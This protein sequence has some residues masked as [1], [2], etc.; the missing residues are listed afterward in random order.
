MQRSAPARRKPWRI[1]LPVMGG[2][3]IIAIGLG[4]W[5]A[6]TGGMPETEATLAPKT[7][8]LT[9]PTSA[10][11]S[12]TASAPE[13][14]SPVSQEVPAAEQNLIYKWLTESDTPEVAADA[15]LANWNQLSP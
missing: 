6:R 5:I 4:L 13:V 8:A 11:L 10:P 1:S 3:V 15:M 2:A 12:T 7:P 14:P 9:G